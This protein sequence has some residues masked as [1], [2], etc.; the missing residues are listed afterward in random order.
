[1]AGALGLFWLKHSHY[2]EGRKWI[3]N[4]LERYPHASDRAKLKAWRWE[5]FMAFWQTDMIEARRIYTQS[6]ELEQALGDQWGIAF[7]L[8]MLANVA[9]VEDDVK[10]ARELHT[11]SI[12]ISREINAVWVLGLSEFSLGDIEYNQGNLALAEELSNKG[13]RHFRQLGEKFGMGRVLSNLGY[14]LCAK[15]EFSAAK[16][17]FLE[18]LHLMKELVDKD[19][20]ALVMNGLAG[21]FQ[22]EGEHVMSAR[23]QGFVIAIEREIGAQLLLMPME[24]GMFDS[25]TKALK[26]FMGNLAYQTEFETGMALSVDEAVSLVSERS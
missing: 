17:T 22:H 2:S 9:Y 15:D 19:G 8:H 6:L 13:L 14:I 3:G 10:T 4:I 18:A 7:S 12:A 25:T 11:R 24:K 1:M 5:G 23:L 20:L 21:I 16:N 26:E